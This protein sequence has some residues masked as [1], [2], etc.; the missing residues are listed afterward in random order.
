MDLEA[1]TEA[2]T[3]DGVSLLCDGAEAFPAM[4]DAIA[5]ARRE[6]LVEMYWFDDTA[7]KALL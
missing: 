6:V 3:P 7:I 2:P 4:L 5:G 1:P